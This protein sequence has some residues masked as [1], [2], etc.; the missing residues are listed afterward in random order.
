MTLIISPKWKNTILEMALKSF[1]LSKLD[2]QM[3]KSWKRIVAHTFESIIKFDTLK[4]WLLSSG[5]DFGKTFLDSKHVLKVYFKPRRK[6]PFLLFL[7][8]TSEPVWLKIYHKSIHRHYGKQKIVLEGTGRYT[9]RNSCLKSMTSENSRICDTGCLNAKPDV[10]NCSS[11]LDFKLW[12]FW[13][14]LVWSWIVEI[15]AWSTI[16]N[17]FDLT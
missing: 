10:L 7:P 4:N 5:Q 9:Q 14:S 2:H 17:Y 1:L 15:Y 11:D 13:L 12:V 8:L 6:N 3:S 16:W